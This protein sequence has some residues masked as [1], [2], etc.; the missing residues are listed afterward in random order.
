[1]GFC[2]N[3]AYQKRRFLSS[4]NENC[5]GASE[6]EK[7]RVIRYSNTCFVIG[8]FLT[9]FLNEVIKKKRVTLGWGFTQVI[10]KN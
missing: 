10:V 9:I 7:N 8:V 4:K 5:K 6:N 2:I 3:Y 1:M